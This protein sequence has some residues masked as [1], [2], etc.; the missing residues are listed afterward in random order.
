MAFVCPEKNE[1]RK[2]LLCQLKDLVNNIDDK[3]HE[4]PCCCMPCPP[5]CAPPCMPCCPPPCTPCCPPP[6]TPCCPPCSPPPSTPCPV[7]IAQPAVIPL[8]PPCLPICTPCPPPCVPVTNPCPEDQPCVPCNP[9][10]MMVC[11]RMPRVVNPIKRSKSR[12]LRASI[13][14]TTCDCIKRN[15]LQDD[16]PRSECHGSP[17]CLTL[18]EPVCGPAEAARTFT[19]SK[20]GKNKD[21]EQYQCYPAYVKMPGGPSPCSPPCCPVGCC[22]P[23]VP[24]IAAPPCPPPIS[25]ENMRP[26][27]KRWGKQSR[28]PGEQMTFGEMTS[29]MKFLVNGK[30]IV[31]QKWPTTQDSEDR[32]SY[33]GLIGGSK[34]RQTWKTLRTLKTNSRDVKPINPI[35][36]DNWKRYYESLLI[37]ERNNFRKENY[38]NEPVNQL[39]R[40]V[41]VAK[42]IEA[43]KT[44]INSKAADPGSIF[45]ERSNR[46][47]RSNCQVA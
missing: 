15:G 7:P 47:I 37:E 21:L 13:L 14:Y 44:M 41:T 38:A 34:S 43:M 46:N 1:R 18:P 23:C 33:M 19:I 22:G 5:P 32:K 17:E 28:K 29:T 2:S 10:Q 3:G 40:E 16:C 26:Q 31:Y 8:V 27:T 45:M 12:E 25:P 11:Y 42:V 30:E 4:D 6:C 35:G 36:M 20:F 9:P 24:L 39:V